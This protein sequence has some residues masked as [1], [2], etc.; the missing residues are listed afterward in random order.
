[1]IGHGRPASLAFALA[2]AAI[3]LCACFTSVRGQNAPTVEPT[4]LRITWGGG[5]AT[6]WQG[7]IRV[8]DGKL[9]DLKLLESNPDAVGSIWI[10]DGQVRV[11]SLSPHK[12]DSVEVRVQPSSA[13][14]LQI[15]LGAIGDS[16]APQLEIPLADLSRR[17]YQSRLGDHGNTLE[18][19]VVPQPNLHIIPSRSPLIFL[20]GEQCSF[21]VSPTIPNVGPGT[22]LSITT[23]LTPISPGC[24]KE[25]PW[26]DTKRL[27]VPVEG[28]PKIALSAPLPQTEGV[29]AVHIAVARP[30]G[31]DKLWTAPSR[32][33]VPTRL[34]EQTLQVVVLDVHSPSYPADGRW[35]SVLE[36]DPTNPG[37]I[38]RLPSWT[39]LRRIPGLNRGALGSTYA[40]VR[41]LPLGRFVELPSNGPSGEPHWQAYSLPLEAVGVPHMLEIDYP[42]D[43][44]Q[45]FGISIVEPN[46]NGFVSGN[47][48]DAGVYVEGLGRSE[49]KQK[50]THRLVFWP[51]TQAPLLVLTNMHPDALAHFGQIRVFKRS[52][53]QLS[54]AGSRLPQH[55]R[56]IA[57]YLA[58][59]T[60]AETFGAARS[61]DAAPSAN[62]GAGDLSDDAEATYEGATRL[63]DY[64]RYSGYN[65]AIVSIR[66]NSFPANPVA[67]PA[68]E[69]D[70]NEVMFRVFDR[71]GVAL[72]P[73]IDFATPLPKLEVARRTSDRQTSGLEWVGPSGRTWLEANGT[74]RGLAPYYNL[75]DPRVQQAML[76][77]ARE[78]IELYSQH[79][80]FAGLAVQLS[81]DGYA[82]LPPLDWGM[83]DAT[84]ARF[85]HETG[86]QIPEAKS[87][88]RFQVR[89]KLLT[90]SQ[91]AAW[92]NWR[93][94]Q[95][96]AFYMQLAALVR[97]NTERRLVLTTENVFANPQIAEVMRP[98]LGQES[99]A[100][101]VAT[102]L[103]NG[104]I[105]R[106]TLE[107]AGIVLCP[108]RFVEPG[109]PLP[110]RA[111]DLELNEVFSSW[112]HPA[113]SAQSRAVVLYHRPMQQRLS[114][115]ELAGRPWRVA[116][117]M[118][119]ACQPLPEGS[120][121]RR[122]YVEAL[123]E[124]DPAMI[125]DG[126]E[127]LPLGQEDVLRELR[128]VLAQL[129]ISAE[130]TEVTK[131]PIVV[132]T[133]VERDRTTI[134][135]MNL[136]PWQHNAVITANVLQAT[137]VE[138]LGQITGDVALAKRL[139]LQAG[140][141]KWPSQLAPYEIS[142]VR[143]AGTGVKVVDVQATSNTSANELSAKL[144]DLNSR[145]LTA[146]SSYSAL[147]NP[148][149]EPTGGAIRTIGW[150]L[151]A[152][153]GKSTAELDATAPQD[154]KTCLHIRSDGNTAIVESDPFPAPS[155]GQLAMTVYAR[156]ESLPPELDPKAPGPLRLII[157]GESGSYR[158]GANVKA[159][160]MQRPNKDWGEPFAMC[161]SDL[162]LQSRGQLQI[163]FELTGA[164]EVWIDNVK[165]ESVLFALKFYNKSNAEWL[166]LSR[167]ISAARSA[168]NAGQIN[169]C[170]R[171]IDSYWPRF[172]L[173]NRPAAPPKVAERVL[174]TNSPASPAEANEAQE[175]SP[176]FSDRLK[177]L[178]PITR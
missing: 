40:Q 102:V 88:D 97:G 81:S 70:R 31:F 124:H 177:R 56:L 162:P 89:A 36:I 153:S 149:F 92:R 90:G 33:A 139:P 113:T 60:A 95:V 116:G 13:A 112:R 109:T 115:F 150:H 91:A 29:Y 173:A 166:E 52:T 156:G 51:H 3:V 18:V 128:Q 50:Q 42:A 127:R 98:N 34:A 160:E 63:V 106:N 28:R 23:T 61:T 100:G 175:P 54:A 147:P 49:A 67:A 79:R 132:R 158:S 174:P 48:R 37:W 133:Y 46:A 25:S 74:R 168:F 148:S 1:M 151:A 69:I 44:E 77:T 17:P 72:L 9:G 121:V 144:A 86:I 53:L 101:R 94:Q 80:S 38:E 30:S 141:Q 45:H 145:D 137:T 10:E 143:I 107:Q 12:V 120:A 125:I 105:D 108:T 6:R 21:D 123:A 73:A 110:E 58:R 62:G 136:S 19:Q 7:R 140:E 138:R 55:Q 82:Q 39:Q 84:V 167:Q 122:P 15:E 83:D 11:A 14:K 111:I 119:L 66:S 26:S 65:S 68:L 22:E 93:N 35:E 118:Q 71:E 134:V 130:V 171:I 104:G 57:A 170:T 159:V 146:R 43:L 155:T 99:P 20:P 157:K 27:E 8:A 87:E 172:I 96:N 59:P 117:E 41:D 64:L 165:L 85:S 76:E 24:K 75:L 5:D 16:S 4:Q 114:S 164:G 2:R 103:A 135:A 142:V 126:G 78:T 154:G 163:R 32:L 131:Q 169:D 152:G 129:P 47:N 176:G 178:W 161:V